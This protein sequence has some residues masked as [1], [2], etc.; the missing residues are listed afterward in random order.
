MA[1]TSLPFA[2]LCKPELRLVLPDNAK[3]LLQNP[4]PILFGASAG[5]VLG[6]DAAN[7]GSCF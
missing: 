4:G 3:G 7:T 6:R 5:L 1:Y 2:L